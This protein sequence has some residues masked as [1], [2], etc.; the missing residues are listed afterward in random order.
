MSGIY[1]TFGQVFEGEI[2]YPPPTKKVELAK[3]DPDAEKTIPDATLAEMQKCVNEGQAA[4]EKGDD[5]SLTEINQQARQLLE[6]LGISAPAEEPAERQPMTEAEI[7]A[8]HEKQKADGN[9]VFVTRQGVQTS[10]LESA[11]QFVES[12]KGMSIDNVQKILQQLANGQMTYGEPLP[13]E[14]SRKLEFARK[15]LNGIKKL[16]PSAKG[17]ESITNLVVT[18]QEI[19]A[20]PRKFNLDPSQTIKM[21]QVLEFLTSGVPEKPSGQ[22]T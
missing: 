17:S 2:G 16:S 5:A 3:S 18:L 1:P 15:M 6:K 12:A 13:L 11:Q 20:Q 4:L 9:E 10:T 14:Y 8:F 7:A 21:N 19:K 22:T